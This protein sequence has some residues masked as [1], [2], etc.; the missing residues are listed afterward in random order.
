MGWKA[1]A[2]SVKIAAGGN[3]AGNTSVIAGSTALIQVFDWEKGEQTHEIRG[4]DFFYERVACHHEGHWL[5]GAGGVGNKGQNLLFFDLARHEVIQET[6]SDQSVFDMV[7]NEASDALY[8]VGRG[9][10]LIQWALEARPTIR[11]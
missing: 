2:I 5:L 10:G 11:V 8:T 7:L 4:G 1:H 3:I 6:K 9:K